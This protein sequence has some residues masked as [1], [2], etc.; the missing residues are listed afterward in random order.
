[1]G[2]RDFLVIEHGTNLPHDLASGQ[3]TL[4]S[5]QGGQAKLAIHGTTDL[6]GN[7]DGR[8]V[9]RSSRGLFDLVPS[10][11]PVSGFAVVAF[12]HP[13][14]FYTLSVGE[15]DEIP[16]RAISGDEFLF[17]RR[18]PKRQPFLSQALPK[19]TRKCGNLFGGPDP[20]TVECLKQLPPA[21]RRL[22]GFL[23][24]IGKFA[25]GQAQ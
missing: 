12:R 3:I 6:A 11:A 8:A 5:E 14:G 4:H 16:N 15:A 17:D 24:E 2:R 7:A 18:N 21:V 9:P 13:D 10:L 22:A 1:M 23:G 20:L 19:L 25:Q